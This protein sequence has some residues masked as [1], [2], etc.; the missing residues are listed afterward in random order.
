MV[1][2]YQTGEYALAVVTTLL[3]DFPADGVQCQDADGDSPLNLAIHSQT[4]QHVLAV[5][6]LLLQA[7]PQAMQYK[8]AS[9]RLSAIAL[10]W[11][12]SRC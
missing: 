8:N 6:E 1:I 9:A 5:I 3:S 7:F 12:W 2:M 10:C 4:G 11:M